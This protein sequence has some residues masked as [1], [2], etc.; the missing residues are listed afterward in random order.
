MEVNLLFTGG[1]DSSLSAYILEK[2]GYHIKTI[3]ATFGLSESW[4]LAG[5]TAEALGYS[6]TAVT[7]DKK[8][9]KRGC[10]IMLDDGY[11]LN[12][13]KYIHRK[14]LHTLAKDYKL[15][16]DGS[17]RDD[18]TPW[19]G[20][21]EIRSLEDKYGV[22]YITPLRG[23]GYKTLRYLTDKLFIVETYDS[24]KGMTADYE[25]EIRVFLGNKAE[26]IFPTHKHT[27]VLNW[28]GDMNGKK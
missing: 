22:E 21:A 28:K 25:T 12:G 6:H 14:I 8:V 9:L 20:L 24:S 17:R 23:I 19:L 13:I 1:K 16:C 27:R 26:S 3:T 10:E 5:E 18:R 11:P 4:K 2:L 15:L 7:I